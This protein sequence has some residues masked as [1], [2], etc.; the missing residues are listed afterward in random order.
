MLLHLHLDVSCGGSG[1]VCQVAGYRQIRCRHADCDGYNRGSAQIG[2]S[3]SRRENV[4]RCG[5][6]CRRR[7]FVRALGLFGWRRL[8]RLGSFLSGTQRQSKKKQ[9]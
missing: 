1:G 6:R 2:L 4:R 7:L 9:K 8:D 3:N 5:I